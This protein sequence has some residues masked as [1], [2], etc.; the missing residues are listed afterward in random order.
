MDFKAGAVYTYV[1]YYFAALK[2]LNKIY[3]TNPA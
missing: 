2:Q 1:Y 3:T